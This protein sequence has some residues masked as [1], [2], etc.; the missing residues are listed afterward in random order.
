MF[1]DLHAKLIR[2]AT[3]LSLLAVVC[4]STP[5]F[6]ADISGHFSDHFIDETLRIDY[7]HT[8]NATE[9]FISLDEMWRQGSWAGSRTDLIDNL[10]LGRYYAKLYDTASGELIWSRGF[11]SY[12]GEWQTTGPAGEGVMRTYHESALTPYPKNPVEFTLEARG[13]G[14]RLEE[15][16]RV[17]IDPDSWTIRQDAMPQGIVKVEGH[18]G[19]DPHNC[20][21][22]A[23]VGEGYTECDT[24]KFIA[25]VQRF[26]QTMILLN[27]Y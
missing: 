27:G 4:L 26:S 18:I 24:A 3:I 6:A 16:Y 19:G 17:G 22:I 14:G 11:D 7:K 15:F 13:E 12:F 25:D 8:G 5:V 10:D 21:D 23:I 1:P 20:V 9:Q 2:P